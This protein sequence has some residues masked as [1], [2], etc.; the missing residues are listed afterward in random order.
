MKRLE[1]TGL[2]CSHTLTPFTEVHPLIQLN[3]LTITK[4]TSISKYAIVEAL[5]IVLKGHFHA[6]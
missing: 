6:G 4:R 1:A 2:Y 5:V 3:I